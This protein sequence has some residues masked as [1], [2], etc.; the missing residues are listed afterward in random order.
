MST[1]AKYILRLVRDQL[2][3]TKDENTEVLPSTSKQC[4]NDSETDSDPYSPDHSEYDPDSDDSSDNELALGNGT[5]QTINNDLHDMEELPVTTDKSRKRKRNEQ[6]W[7]RNIAKSRKQ[8][9]EAYL[10]SRGKYVP[11]VVMKDACLAT[12]KRKC[13]EKFSYEERLSIFRRYYQLESYERKRDFIN[14]H[15]EKKDKKWHTAEQSRRQKTILFYLPKNSN[16]IQ[17]CKTMFINTLGIRKGI[18]DIAMKKRTEENTTLV[19][20]RGKHTKK[21]TSPAILASVK[22]HIE[23]FPVVSSHYCRSKTQRKYLSSDLNIT[24]MYSL[25]KKECGE[26]NQ[27]PANSAIYRKVFSEEYNLGFYRPRKDQCR[28][29]MAYNS[30]LSDKA[31]M[32]T[33]Y[34]T[35][36]AAKN[37]ARDEKRLSRQLAENSNGTLISCNFDLQQVLLVPND[38]TNNALF[39]KQRL[40]VFNFTIYN[41][42]SKQGDCFMWTEVEGKRGSCEI[43]TCL[44]QYFES[45]PEQVTQ[46]QCFSDRCGGQN[47]NKNVAS[48]CLTAVQHIPHLESIELN[49]LVSGHSEMECDSMH[50]AISTEFKRVGK[51]HLPQDWK[52]IARCARRKGDK[53]YIIHNIT[54]EQ[55]LDWKNH[56]DKILIFRGKDESGQQVAWQKMCCMFFSKCEPSIMKFKENFNEEFRTLNCQRR[57][58]STQNITTIMPYPLYK[59]RIPISLEKYKD[60]LTLFNTKPPAIPLENKD[61]FENLPFKATGREVSSESD[62]SETE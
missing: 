7:K 35:H 38:P 19:D 4:Y 34:L 22:N 41:T 58:K 16:R 6:N 59:D 36:I 29:C 24:I 46:V 43:A 9:G 8:R 56:A 5:F 53:P 18:V 33:E 37:R 12:C 23:K 57:T 52:T 48:M 47:L 3:E 49:F 42:V 39:Y 21:I 61:Y 2:T 10:S 17:V 26:N 60:L 62:I 15:T 40:K 1:R 51:T 54:H 44:Y 31:S 45:L 55:I 28:V 13:T 25:Y 50:S 20:N 32:E 11:G 14:G 27:T 30:P